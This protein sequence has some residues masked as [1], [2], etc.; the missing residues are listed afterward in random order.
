MADIT[1]D[2]AT[3]AEIHQ[4]IGRGGPF[5]TTD[6]I[7][8]AIYVDSDGT[9]VYQKTTNGGANWGGATT[10]VAEVVDSADCWA[11]WQTAGDSGTKI[12]VAYI[13]SEGDDVSYI[14]LDTNGDS[15][16]GGSQIE[17]AQGTNAVF[18]ISHL[19]YH[20]ISITKSRGGNLAVAARYIDDSVT[21]F[22][23]FYTSPD[24][25]A[26]TSKTSPYETAADFTQLYPGNEADNNDIWAAFWDRSAD[27]ISLKTFDNSG[28]SW[29]EQS[30]SG[31]MEDNNI[32]LQMDGQIRLSDGHLIFAAWSQYDNAAAD[33]MVW[34]INGAGSITA[35]TNVITNESE[36]FMVSVF[37]NQVNDD[38]YIAYGSGTSA[39]SAV[40]V[41][42]Q[43][44]DDGGGSWGGETVYQSNVEDDERWISAGCMK[45]TW[46]GKFQPVWF[47]DDIDDIF[48]NTDNG[49]SIAAAEE[50]T[51]V[52]PTT[53]ALTITKYISVLKEVT[54]PTTLN[55]SDTQYIPILKEVTT[56]TT[57]NL[58]DT[59]YIPILK[60][61]L[62]PT[63]LNLSDTEYIPVLKEI[64]TPGTLSLTLSFYIPVMGT[65]VIPT[66]LSLSDT[67]YIPIL[68]EVTT[69]GTLSL[70]LTFYAVS[71][72]EPVLLTPA[73][74]SLLLT[75]YIPV[76]APG[77]GFYVGTV[78]RDPLWVS[79][80]PK[81]IIF[82]DVEEEITFG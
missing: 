80:P 4:A 5:W 57:L 35:K 33:L 43:L 51:I 50:G 30:I 3:Y 11:D 23:I 54:T 71:I 77:F 36:S 82:T 53:L 22:E 41:F 81:D 38:I 65:G 39:S 16:A 47:N 15:V 49:I 34:D 31:S 48:C 26:W 58:S 1:I 67:E 25:S 56:P 79:G 32:G 13:T 63:T 74:L 60:E 9:L 20:Q 73:T 2:N 55:L 44:S 46:G 12:H 8:Y 19:D 21:S 37:I 52:T 27:E 69:P 29:G 62:T 40:K 17:A 45:A 6:S 10:I 59:L 28:N 72:D 78:N 70:I 14:Y 61:T 7:G 18:H 42:Y 64:T 76:P 24:A 75:G 68:K 66:T